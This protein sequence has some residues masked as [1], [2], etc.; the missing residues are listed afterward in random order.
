MDKIEKIIKSYDFA[1]KDGQ[2]IPFLAMEKCA[3][4]LALHIGG[5]A[6]IPVYH[7]LL[8]KYGANYLLEGLKDY[9]E[10]WD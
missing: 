1:I 7:E 2:M 8:T 3:E 5:I 6:P 4:H 10:S 9:A